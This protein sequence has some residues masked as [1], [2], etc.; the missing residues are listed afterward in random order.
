M[1]LTHAATPAKLSRR[2]QL[3]F[4]MS[5]IGYVICFIDRSAISITLPYI[6]KEMQ[7][8]TATL[9]IVSSA[10]F[11]S[12]ALMQ[13]PG[14]WLTDKI[15]TYKAI[16]IAISMWSFFTLMT[17]F[18]WSLIALVVIRV[19]FGIGEGMFPSAALTSISESFPYDKRSTGTANL[20]SSNEIG[21]AVA[22]MLMAPIIATV[23][24]RGGFH[25][26]GI[27]GLLFVAA[28]AAMMFRY[29]KAASNRQQDSTRPK[30]AWRTTLKDKMIW[31]FFLIVFGVSATT[32]GM[33]SWMPTYLLTTRHINLA[34]LAWLVPLPSIAA[35]ISAVLAGWL[36]TKL[37]RGHEKIFL[38]LA[39]ILTTVS[40]Y[41]MYRSTSLI[42][43]VTWE[44]LTYF[45]KSA[46]F[47]GAFAFFAELV[48]KERY[49]SAIGI[50]NF[51]GQLAGFVAPLAIGFIVTAFKGA[52]APAFLFLVIC[53]ALASITALLMNDKQLRAHK[54]A[55]Q[56]TPEK[57]VTP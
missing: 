44:I 30:I 9:G 50:V 32:K 23:G 26:V 47:S 19:L 4:L 15:G 21:A 20:I 43:V 37:F 54:Q 33:D 29:R 10:F 55:V 40:M 13:I 3:A 17:G 11:F 27:I 1:E 2:A 57:E 41:I 8:S 12:Y 16:I 49:G 51:G 39:A 31:E 53:A 7:L 36:L 35:G 46:A 45:F 25:V 28:F 6:G 42:S 22:P 56:G 14:G 24:W 38:A 5:Y 34:N 18:A 52:Y 48:S